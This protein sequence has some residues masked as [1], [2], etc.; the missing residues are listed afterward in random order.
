MLA[1]VA[2]QV[3]R[4]TTD[5][6]GVMIESHL[7]AGKQAATNGHAGLRYGQSITD[8]C[9]DLTTTEHMLETLARARA[10]R[11]F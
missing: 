6:L 8:A 9:V 5:I 7:V 11:S 10:H 4:G 2:N 1:E 3:A